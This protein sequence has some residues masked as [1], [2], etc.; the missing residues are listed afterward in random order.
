MK[1]PKRPITC[2]GS[3]DAGAHEW[4]YEDGFRHC[5]VCGAVQEM[6]PIVHMPAKAKKGGGA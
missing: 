3:D 2:R 1:P 6:P 5:L 4:D